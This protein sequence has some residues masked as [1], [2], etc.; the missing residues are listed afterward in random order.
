MPYVNEAYSL[1]QSSI[2]RVQQDDVEIGDDIQE[3]NVITSSEAIE[4]MEDVQT[5]SAEG[6]PQRIR[7]TYDQFVDIQMMLAHKVHS[8]QQESDDGKL[9][10]R[11]PLTRGNIH[12]I[13]VAVGLRFSALVQWYLEEREEYLDTEED[14][15][16]EKTIVEKVIK[17]LTRPVRRDFAE[18]RNFIPHHTVH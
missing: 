17:K 4:S 2:I 8:L 12:S 13:N 6:R 10:R 14:Y 18:T 3:S 7:I 1:L 5:S 11:N 15:Q 9:I 16:R